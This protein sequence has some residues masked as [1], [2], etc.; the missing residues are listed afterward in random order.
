MKIPILETERLILRPLNID[1]AESVYKW[2]SDERV[3]KYMIYSRHKSIDDT[4]KFIASLENL[5]DNSY[6]W[7]F[8]LK[9]TAKLIGSGGIRYVEKEKAWS[10]GYNIRYDCW[11]KGYTTEAAKCMINFAYSKCGARDFIS[12]HAIDNP[13]S[14]RVMEKCGLKFSHFGA[15]TK[16]DGSEIFKAKDYKMR[17]D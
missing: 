7:G 10:F 11:N 13:A 16:A 17:L 2:A 9:D 6:E 1:D 12:E 5:P 4:K 3:A 14:G 15:Y 8:L